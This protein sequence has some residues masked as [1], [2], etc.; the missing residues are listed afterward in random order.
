MKMRVF[1]DDKSARDHVASLP[2]EARFVERTEGENP[3]PGRAAARAAARG[4]LT[5]VPVKVIPLKDGT[6]AVPVP[7]SV[8]STQATAADGSKYAQ[9][10]KTPG[11]DALAVEKDERADLADL[12]VATEKREP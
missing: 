7:L 5:E 3:R 1:S 11:I 8:T 2:P 4:V 10:T 12:A 6:F 9:E